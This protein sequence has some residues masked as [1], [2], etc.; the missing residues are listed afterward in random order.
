M[1]LMPGR[2]YRDP[3]K[4]LWNR[5]D[6]QKSYAMLRLRVGGLAPDFELLPIEEV[7]TI[8]PK[9]T[10]ADGKPI[11]TEAAGPAPVERAGQLERQKLSVFRGK[12]PVLLLFGSFT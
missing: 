1:E 9:E 3:H 6:V 11:A 12:K 10:G 8:G 5:G 4:D 2:I 7:K